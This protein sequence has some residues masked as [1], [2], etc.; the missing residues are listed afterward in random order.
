MLE[1]S[2]FQGWRRNGRWFPRGRLGWAQVRRIRTLIGCPASPLPPFPLAAVVI[3]PLLFLSAAGCSLSL[4][5]LPTMGQVDTLA[6]YLVPFYI[7]QYPTASP[8]HPDSFHDSAY[9]NVGPLDICIVI[10]CIAAMAILRDALRLGFFEPLARW[11]LHKD[12]ASKLKQ[13]TK[14]TN[15]E[16]LNGASNG[17][18][19]LANGNGTANG[20]PNGVTNGHAKISAVSGPS[21]KELRQLNRKVL[22]FA[23][24][25]WSVVYYTIQWG[26]GLVR[27]SRVILIYNLFTETSFCSMSTITSQP[28][29]S[30]QL[31]S[32]VN[33]HIYPS[34]VLSNS[35]I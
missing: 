11:K 19:H 2:G 27:Y 22:R 17:N 5:F 31:T 7:L 21:T 3:Y 32:G 15:L 18:G 20:K 10:S 8:A 30:S 6:S 13:R 12:L 24:Q 14:A 25:G 26:F 23:E 16:E 35:T 34:P 29:Y 4:L 28:A 1:V 9:Y 33:T